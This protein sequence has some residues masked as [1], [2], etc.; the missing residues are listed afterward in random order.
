MSS[1]QLSFHAFGP[2][3][4][5]QLFSDHYL[6]AI[7]PARPEFGALADRVIPIMATTVRG[8]FAAYT[9]TANEAQLERDL[10]RPVLDALGH[11]YEVQPSLKSPDGTKAPDYV[12]YA[13]SSARNANK[14]RVLTDVLAQ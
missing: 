5:Q 1:D 10:V 4:N 13:D 12:L 7:L 8:I 6:D 2:H 3:N 14:N 11:Q 9:P